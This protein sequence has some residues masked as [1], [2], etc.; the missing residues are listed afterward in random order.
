MGKIARTRKTV[1]PPRPS[2]H[3]LLSQLADHLNLSQPAACHDGLADPK[4]WDLEQ[5]AYFALYALEVVRGYLEHK[6]EGLTLSEVNACAGLLDWSL[7]AL[8][9]FDL[10]S[11]G[12]RL[13]NER[14]ATGE[15]RGLHAIPRSPAR[16][17]KEVAR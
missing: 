13:E 15:P 4:H 8:N 11:L 7:T 5:Q 3:D 16:Q 12:I 10:P 1:T 14:R 2:L 9:A 17:G 6:P